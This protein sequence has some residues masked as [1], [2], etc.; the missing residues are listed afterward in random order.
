MQTASGIRGWLHK[1]HER[2]VTCQ[3][4]P[5][6][7]RH[8]RAGVLHMYNH[9]SLLHSGM[10]THMTVDVLNEREHHSKTLQ[11]GSPGAAVKGKTIE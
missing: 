1:W 5:E 4:R 6:G 11:R 10:L 7:C 9:C 2:M 3:A 8:M